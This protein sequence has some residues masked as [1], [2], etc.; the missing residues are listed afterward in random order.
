M[1]NFHEQNFRIA[2]NAHPI[3][4]SVY[5]CIRVG[6]WTEFLDLHARKALHSFNDYF[7]GGIN[8]S[9]VVSFL[10]NS[11][12]SGASPLFTLT[13][14]STGGPATNVIWTRDPGTVIGDKMTV[15]NDPV[16]AQY[17]HSLTVTGRLG[18]LYTCNVSNRQSAD[19][20]SITVEGKR[21]TL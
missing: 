3:W 21:S 8:I 13:C 15:L 17:T 5:A 14:N 16:T 9:G 4:Y 12:L 2:K 10:V 18:G 19:E 6:F 20:K 7:L 1:E 11:D